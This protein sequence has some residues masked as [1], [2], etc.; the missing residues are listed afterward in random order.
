MS[1]LRAIQ[2]DLVIRSAG[3]ADRFAVDRLAVLDSQPP[4]DG[5]VLLGLVAGEAWAAIS[6]A[7]GRAVADPFRPSAGVVE[8]LRVRAEHLR[9]GARRPRPRTRVLGLGRAAA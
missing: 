6:L 1:H 7:D 9:A 5:E 3:E 2:T 4:L 8:L